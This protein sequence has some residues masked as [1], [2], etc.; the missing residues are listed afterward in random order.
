MKVLLVN[1]SPHQHGCTYTA[2]AEIAIHCKKKAL[3]ARS[4]GSETS[5]SAAASAATA[6]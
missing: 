4:F 6:V 5:P 3:T 2:L 1:G